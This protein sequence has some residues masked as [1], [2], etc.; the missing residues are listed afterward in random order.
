M[1]CE[2]EGVNL[3]AQKPNPTELELLWPKSKPK[4]IYLN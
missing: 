1:Q 3:F 2:S 4:L